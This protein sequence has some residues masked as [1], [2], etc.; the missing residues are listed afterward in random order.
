MRK[1]CKLNENKTQHIKSVRAMKAVVKGMFTVLYV[2][3]IKERK[4]SSL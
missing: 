2:L 3:E 4:A 1:C